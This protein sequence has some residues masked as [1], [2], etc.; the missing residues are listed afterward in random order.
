MTY[1]KQTAKSLLHSLL[2][3]FTILSLTVT[4]FTNPLLPFVFLAYSV[5]VSSMVPTSFLPSITCLSHF[6]KLSILPPFRFAVQFL[7]APSILSLFSC[8]LFFYTSFLHTPAPPV[9]PP[10]PPLPCLSSHSSSSTHPM[11]LVPLL[12]LLLL[13]PSHF[14]RPTP[15]PP[16]IPCL[17]SHSSSSS[18]S[19]SSS[20]VTALQEEKGSLLAENQLLMERLNHSDSIEDVNSPAGRRHLQLQTQLEQLQEETFR[21]DLVS[22]IRLQII[23]CNLR[24]IIYIVMA[25]EPNSGWTGCISLSGAS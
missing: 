9:P 19:S 6:L 23:F 5:F 16:P 20:Q 10:P 3:C 2:S 24:L 17:S 25:D 14:S 1:Q 8:N 18:S 4:F 15:P 13:H 7:Y 22:Q 21:Q 12:L 11:P